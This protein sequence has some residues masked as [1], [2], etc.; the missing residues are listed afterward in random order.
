MKKL[1]VLAFVA[2]LAGGALAQLDTAFFLVG[3]VD[4]SP[5]TVGINKDILIPVYFYGSDPAVFVND[6]CLPIA[7]ESLIID[8]WS[9]T[10]SSFDFPPINGEG[11]PHEWGIAEFG[12]LND[13]SHPTH[14]NLPGYISMSFNGNARYIYPNV[15]MLHSDVPIQ[16]LAYSFH[17]VDS[18]LLI[19]ETVCTLRPGED[20]AQGPP[21][22]G[23]S[24]GGPGFIPAMQFS[25]L[26]FSPNQA[27]EVISVGQ[28]PTC[29]Y[30]DFCIEVVISDVDG[31][32]VF[33]TGPGDWT[34]VNTEPGI[35]DELI[36]TYEVCFDMEAYCGEC[37]D[38]TF[39]FSVTD[40]N[41]DPVTYTAPAATAI[42]GAITASFA[43]YTEFLPGE[44]QWVPVYL[45]ACG[46]CFCLG[47]FVLTFEWDAS[48][49]SVSDIQRGAYLADGEYW[50]V[51]Y[52]I[53]GPGT[54]RVTFINNLSNCEDCDPICDINADAP[55]FMVKFLL[56]P[57]YQYQSDFCSNICFMYDLPGEN[58]FA[59]NNITDASGYT[60]WFNDGCQDPP[61][62]TFYGTFQLNLEC[63][64]IRILNVHNIL[65][66]DINANGYAN[67]VG[68]VVLLANH[69]MDPVTYWF[70]LRQM[71]ASDANGDGLQATIGDLVFMINALNGGGVAK[72]VPIDV[73]AMVTI[74]NV[75]NG[76][77]PVSV[78]SDASVGGA[79]VTINHPGVELGV[80][81]AD[82]MNLQY[83]DNNDV[84][85]V[86]VY[87]M[88]SV[89]FASGTN[90]LFTVP[91]LSEGTV[92]FGEVSVADNRGALLDSRT[93]VSAPIPT[94]FS[95]SQNFPNPF[96]AKTSINFALPTAADNATINIYNVAG[97]LVHTFD[98]G[99]V[100]AGYQTVV[101]DA[102]DVA[103][104]IYFYKVSAGDFTKTLK[105]TL[106]K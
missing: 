37:A 105:M 77:L 84:M 94:E 102:S 82:G 89:S 58:H 12:N 50:N 78:T 85:T 26:F 59:Y 55:L 92:S 1:L 30:T 91:V 87:N 33:I 57:A 72:V 64:Q 49:L 96:N 10:L 38:F 4:G 99:H 101:W 40:N 75:F 27:P 28:M 34:L 88:Q 74:P 42:V 16:V 21:N 61:D 23:D 36:Y 24:T 76:N 54:A 13:D 20:P 8:H 51:V 25:C 90:T 65:V 32:P 35:G 14:P 80:P 47:G 67:D 2:L 52:G 3:N 83:S 69:L 53:A 70:T 86:V 15:N 22:V 7:G 98:L 81:T 97:Q 31:D 17:T 5:F 63:G 44:E 6:V 19:G 43:P 39:G 56:N 62:S 93:S 60:V 45:D 95:V 68:D 11:G 73:A 104:G 106:L 41:N 29:T 100:A 71:Y 46:D 66:G 79:V 18:T 9:P 103:S 48:V